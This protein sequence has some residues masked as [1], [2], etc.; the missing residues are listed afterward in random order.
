MKKYLL[1]TLVILSFS[2]CAVKQ[3]QT[4]YFADDGKWE[5]INKNKDI[6]NGK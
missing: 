5:I 4:G 1:L 6:L 2:A 3:T